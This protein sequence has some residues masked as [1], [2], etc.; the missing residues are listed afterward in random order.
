MRLPK[1]RHLVRCFFILSI[2]FFLVPL[3]NILLFN[4]YLFNILS[5]ISVFELQKSLCFHFLDLSSSTFT[6]ISLVAQPIR[7]LEIIQHTLRE[8]IGKKNVTQRGDL[9]KK[10]G[11][12]GD[13]RRNSKF[14]TFLDKGEH[15]FQITPKCK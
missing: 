14:G 8:A 1:I 11:G 2:S 15:D 7:Y 3:I 6:T 9:F 12:V 5:F 13:Q 10:R 4:Y